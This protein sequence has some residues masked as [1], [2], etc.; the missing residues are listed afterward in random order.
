M[1][2][3]GVRNPTVATTWRIVWKAK[4]NMVTISYFDRPGEKHAGT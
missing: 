2:E 3:L 4:E 1:A